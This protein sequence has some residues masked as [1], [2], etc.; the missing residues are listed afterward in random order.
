MPSRYTLAQHLHI[1]NDPGIKYILTRLLR[2][3]PIMEFVP[4]QDINSM[5]VRSMRLSTLPSTE[6]RAINSGYTKSVA[7]F[8]F[9]WESLYVMGGEFEFDRLFSK[10]TD[11]AIPMEQAQMNAKLKSLAFNWKDYFVNGDHASDPIGFEGLKKRVASLPSRQTVYFAG[12]SSA[13]LDP[14]GSA[15]N[16]RQYLKILRQ[17]HKRCNNRGTSIILCNEGQYLGLGEVLTYVGVSGGNILDVTQDTF[18]REIAT[19]FGAPMIDTGL[20]VDQSTEIITDTE[21]AGDGGAD[22]TSMYFV[23]IGD[24][25]GLLG[26]QNGNYDFYDPLMGA[27][28]ET[29]PAKLRRL[30]WVNGIATFGPYGVVRARNIEAADDWT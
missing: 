20:K 27:E 19:A 28:M 13:P 3:N 15:A 6:F 11:T 25:N 9:Y 23:S 1:E 12:S 26:L 10:F 7:D 30:E 5:H 17:A 16:A 22:S 18:G 8:S 14:T 2:D 21:T 4:F 29:K 24:E